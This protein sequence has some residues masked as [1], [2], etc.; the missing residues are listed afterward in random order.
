MRL[1]ALLRAVTG[2]VAHGYRLNYRRLRVGEPAEGAARTKL[3]LVLSYC[4]YL[5]TA[6]GFTKLLTR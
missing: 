2:S 4:S 3:L 1:P 6:R 5:V